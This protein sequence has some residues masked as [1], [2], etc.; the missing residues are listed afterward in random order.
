[1]NV[2]FLGPSFPPEMRDFT[3]GLAQAGARV[4]GVGD[5]PPHPSIVPYLSAYLRV[6]SLIHSADVHERVLAWINGHSIDDVVG[7]WEPTMLTA[8]MLRQ[9][10]GLNGMSV[11]QVQGFRDKPLMRQRVAAAG[12]R[13]PKTIRAKSVHEVL[14][15][16]LEIGYPL[17]IKPVDGAGS[18]DTY[19]IDNL[20]DLKTILPRFLH[21]QEVSVEEFI[22]GQEFTYETIC[23]N[24]RPVFEGMSRYE[25]NTLEARQNEWISPI[26]QSLK[27]LNL[28]HL[29][30]ARLMGQSALKA[31]GM[32]TGFTHMEWF[33]TDKGEVVFGEIACRSPGANMVDLMN[34]AGDIDLYAAWGE[35]LV[36]GGINPLRAKSRSAAIVFKRATGKGYIRRIT[37]LHTFIHKY[38]PHIARVDLLPV[39][40]PRR[41]WQ[42]TFLSDGNIVVR[43]QDP[44]LTLRM[45]REA[46]RSIQLFASP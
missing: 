10:L 38:R 20:Q 22:R 39:G 42:Q 26:I 21:V 44:E 24:G 40:S 43:H 11:E 19:V 17:V 18:A 14:E 12:V 25:P 32:G 13:I 45:A 3:R 29:R 36:H 31:L 9:S 33:L 46:A 4:F 35:A 41:N 5:G 27:N 16:A 2:V 1:M 34:F 28:P 30:Q 7:N 23:I 8:A 37:G 6:P 15:A